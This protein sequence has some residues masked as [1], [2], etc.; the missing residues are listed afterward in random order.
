LVVVEKR[1]ALA[2][3]DQQTIDVIQRVNYS[4]VCS[5]LELDLCPFASTLPSAGHNTSVSVSVCLCIQFPSL[6]D[7]LIAVIQQPAVLLIVTYNCFNKQTSAP[8][9]FDAFNGV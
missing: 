2:T 4:H 1:E 6:F 3:N 9:P 5:T 8:A 7:Q